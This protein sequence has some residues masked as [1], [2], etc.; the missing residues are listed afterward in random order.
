MRD[1]AGVVEPRRRAGLAL[2]PLARPALARDDLDGHLALELLVPREPYDAEPSG[3]QTALH[4]VAAEDELRAG[5][6]PAGVV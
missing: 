5:S 6:R 2:D 4:P 3:A 1:D